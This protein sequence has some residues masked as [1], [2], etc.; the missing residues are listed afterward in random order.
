MVLWR[1]ERALHVDAA[2]EGL[3]ARLY[4][5][6]W[7]H[8]GTAIVYLSS[9]LS[10]SAFERFVHTLPAGKFDG[11]FA[12]GV[13]LPDAAIAD[14]A[15]PARLPAGWRSPHPDVQT[16]NW[17]SAWAKT[18]SSLLAAV[19]SALLPLELYEDRTEYNLMLNPG[20]AGIGL[21]RVI[22]RH[23]YAFDGRMWK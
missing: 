5:G 1:I 16:A 21:A 4:G 10:L 12:V 13:E 15:R 9:T 6:R 23:P 22:V 14:A 17:G 18:R 19:P 2:L 3:G 11:L 20:H 8:A 7:N